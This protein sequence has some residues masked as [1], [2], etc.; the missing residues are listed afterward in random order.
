[1]RV[2]LLVAGAGAVL[3]SP[4]R[5]GEVQQPSIIA[6]AAVA[7]D[8]DTLIVE[9]HRIRIRALYAPGMSEPGGAAAKEMAAL[10]IYGER[11]VCT[12]GLSNLMSGIS[13]AA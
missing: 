2:A 13:A 11:V 12:V 6:G 5:S 8:G 9:G 10:A 4:A 1:M 7:V 3:P